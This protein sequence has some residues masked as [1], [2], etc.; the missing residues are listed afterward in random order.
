MTEFARWLL[1]LLTRYKKRNIL[2]TLRGNLTSSELDPAGSNGH[3][4]TQDVC[5]LH[6]FE[7]ETRRQ[8]MSR[9]ISSHLLQRRTREGDGLNFGDV[10]TLGLLSIFR[11]STPSIES[12]L[13]TCWG[14]YE[15]LW[16]VNVVEKLS[17]EVLFHQKNAPAH[18]SF[19][20]TAAV[21][22]HE[23]ELVDHPPYFSW[24]GL[25]LINICSPAWKR[26]LSGNTTVS[27]SK[28]CW[29]HICCWWAF[30]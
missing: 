27:A 26:D 17:K 29:R 11:R 6:H 2:I 21:R 13:P 15:R 4:L 14:S 23:F 18:T 5:Y 10:N 30:D 24:L 1:H 8:T 20:S 25:H 22:D 19:L 3:F 12:N 16:S 7:L 9:N 28:W